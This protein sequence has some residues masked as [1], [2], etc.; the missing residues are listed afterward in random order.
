MHTQANITLEEAGVD[1]IPVTVVFPDGRPCGANA[2]IFDP[3]TFF[4]HLATRKLGC[5]SLT[6]ASLPSTQKL[7]QQNAGRVPDGVVCVAD[8]QE[9]GKGKGTVSAP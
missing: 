1:A 2:P 9:A 5:V 3:H 4:E 7:L 6:A 8:R